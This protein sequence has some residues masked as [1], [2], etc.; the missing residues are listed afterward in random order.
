MSCL[1]LEGVRV[2]DFTHAVAGPFASM[3][4]AD[5]GAEVIKVEPPE[6]D[7]VRQA[8]PVVGGLSAIFAASN[9]NKKSIVV[10][11]RHPRAREVVSRLAGSSHVVLENFRPGVREKLG[12][13]PESL[14][15]V[16]RNLVYVSIKGFRPDSQYGG[17]PAYDMVVQAMSGLMMSLGTPSDPPLRVP[18]ALF[19]IFTGY[20]AA[21]EAL[22]GLYSGVRP[23]YAEAYLFD[24]GIYSMNY[25]VNA[26][27]ATGRDP[28]RTGHEHPSYAPHQAYA[29]SDG[30]W[31]VVAVVNDRQWARLC[32]A[33]GLKDL[34]EDRGLQGNLAR[35]ER[36][37]YINKKLQEVFSTRPRDYWV[38]LLRRAGV[39]AAP[40]YT[41]SELF[42]D[43]YSKEDVEQVSGSPYGL[44]SFPGRLNG[45]R[46]AVRS[47]PPMRQGEHTE[48]VLR[49]LGFDDKE[50]ESLRAD[51]VVG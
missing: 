42:S 43:P 49:E 46:P 29:G 35:V 45:V 25:L 15:K 26:F 1:P 5:M 19:D 47:P 28:G 31:F 40:V 30:R 14:F 22:A 4:L 21:L 36:R 7:E 18:F 8:A 39:P 32:E 17:L 13:D 12:V 2:L 34:A 48:E 38:E 41:L 24:V 6:G 50:V 37:D 44:I 27:L 11:L 10:N 51:G 23:Y 20:M 9:R 3:L 33:L 16:N